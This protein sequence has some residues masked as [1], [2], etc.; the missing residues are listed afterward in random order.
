MVVGSRTTTVTR[1]TRE[2]KI[3]LALNI[4]GQGNSTIS[5]G[6][7][8]LD[9]LISQISRHGLFDIEL[10][11]KGDLDVG[12]HHLVEDTAICLGR[13]FLDAMGDKRGI[14]RMSHAV[15]P[16]DDSLAMVAV[17]VS[18]RGYANVDCDLKGQLVET[19]PGE[20]VQ[21]FLETFAVEAKMNLHVRVITGHNAHHKAECIFKGLAKS[22]SYALSQN[23][24]APTDIPSTKGLLDE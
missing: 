18:G 19:L 17:D 6:N 20:M 2:T 7:G 11:A 13:A 12:W 1:N 22:L 21:H 24:R 3:T 14:H 4:D 16:L 15:V 10:N 23:P 5:T 9:H 8:M